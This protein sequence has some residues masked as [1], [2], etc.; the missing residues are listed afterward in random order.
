MARRRCRNCPNEPTPEPLPPKTM[1][2]LADEGEKLWHQSLYACHSVVEMMAG[3]VMLG[4]P[5]DP[6][7]RLQKLAARINQIIQQ[8]E[9]HNASSNPVQ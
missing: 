2:V 3:Y 4:V 9:E 7:R 8:Y 5:G 6:V 1:N